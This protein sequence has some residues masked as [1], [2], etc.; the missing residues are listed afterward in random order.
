MLSLMFVLCISLAC[1]SVVFGLGGKVKKKKKNPCCCF[2][3]L[4]LNAPAK[5]KVSGWHG[6]RLPAPGSQFSFSFVSPLYFLWLPLFDL[7]FHACPL[8]T[9]TAPPLSHETTP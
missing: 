1:V 4:F 8:Y 5:S 6:S 9:Q 3:R 2:F 7:L